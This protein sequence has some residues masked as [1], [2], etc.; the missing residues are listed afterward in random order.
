[1]KRE[2]WENQIERSKYECEVHCYGDRF[3]IN[4]HTISGDCV[5]CERNM[6]MN[7]SKEMKANQE[8]KQGDNN[9]DGNKKKDN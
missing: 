6:Q 5:G 4:G 1:M 8:N 3:C 7:K 2:E 9:N